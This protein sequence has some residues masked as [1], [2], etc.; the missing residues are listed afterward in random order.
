MSRPIAPEHVGATPFPAGH[1]GGNPVFVQTGATTPVV[2]RRPS[3]ATLLTVRLSSGAATNEAEFSSVAYP[4][5][6]T[7]D[8]AS[9]AADT[10]TF[11]APH[12]LQTGDGPYQLTQVGALPGGLAESTNYWVYV[13][14]ATTIQLCANRS[15]AIRKDGSNMDGDVDRP[16]VIDLTTNGSGAN[17]LDAVMP[18]EL[19]ANGSSD[20]FSLLAGFESRTY[21]FSAPESMTVRL[22][23]AGV[24]LQL[25]WS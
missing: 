12:G 25:W 2:Y 8:S 19:S 4:G 20:I 6:A 15:N 7:F 21:H 1:L 17:T 24:K 22:S 9:A 11:T 14:D 16:T 5:T 10:I 23:A 3:G 18:A 13:V